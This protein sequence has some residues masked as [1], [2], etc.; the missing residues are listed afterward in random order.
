MV[1]NIYGTVLFWLLG[2]L[3][4]I[5]VRYILAKPPI[6]AKPALLASII[7]AFVLYMTAHV[8][9]GF[10]VPVNDDGSFAINSSMIMIH[11]I[12]VA[13]LSSW[14][15]GKYTARQAVDSLQG[16]SLK[17]PRCRRTFSASNEPKEYDGDLVC[18]DCLQEIKNY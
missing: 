5:T 3:P 14:L 16:H 9:I 13:I 15:F 8:V 12:A 11:A 2:L 4:V 10:I 6:H 17:C 7:W 1:Y 18:E